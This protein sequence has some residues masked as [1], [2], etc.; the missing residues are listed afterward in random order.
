MD[1]PGEG[2]TAASKPE[3]IDVEMQDDPSIPYE[4]IADTE[5][6]PGFFEG[7]AP[8]EVE[9]GVVEGNEAVGMDLGDD[10]P[11]MGDLF[12]EASDL[13]M[14]A[15]RRLEQ[16]LHPRLDVPEGLVPVIGE[17]KAPKLVRLV[18]SVLISKNAKFPESL[19]M[20]GSQVW[21]AK[22]SSVLSEVDGCPLDVQLA[23]EGRRT[24]LVSMDS[25]KAGR[26]VSADEA[27]SF[28][29]KHGVRIIPTRWVI[30]PKMVSGKEAVR[31]RCVVQDVAKGSTAS[32]LGIS[33]TTPS[34]EALRTLLAIAATDSMEIATLDVSTA[35]LHSPLPRDA[36]A[37][38]SLPK[39]VSS[40]SDMYAPA[41]MILD[42]AMNGLRVAAKAW[43]MKLAKV[44]KQIG[45][46][47][48]P[49]EPSVFEGT[50]T[51][52]RFLMLCYVDDLI[53]CG[54]A[55]AIRLVTDTLNSDLKIKETGRISQSGGKIVFLGREIERHGEHL[56][57]RVPP[58]Y[59]E[60]LFE[61]DFC[62]DLKALTTPPDI[63]KI[64]ENGRADPEKDHF[65]SD[66]AAS[67]YRAVLGRIAW[68]GQSRPD[69]SRWMS[70]LSQGQS[71][72]TA[73]FEHA[74]RQVIRFLKS[75]YLHWQYYGPD[76]EIPD[77]GAS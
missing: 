38:I 5:M 19:K 46:K 50:L 21:L 51:G 43:N 14:R 42:Q 63:V 57:M 71:K 20:C 45:L 59:M 22:P 77:G 12:D 75:Q 37:V 34:L 18:N 53:L 35:F 67:R 72:P 16:L 48:C 32:S 41:Y 13:P 68:W 55:E 7:E 61:T 49:T 27:R 54:C 73:C 26:I 52:K 29:S 44:V 11:R 40:R 6:D 74:L 31:A 58:T 24:E 62:K 33:A 70:I 65:L 30:G 23:I 25:H 17:E 3:V 2:S 56:R 60:S 39:D 1:R 15:P 28:A 66:S 76:G 47:Q 4:N 9:Q 10:F 64:I 36:K 8:M 69:L